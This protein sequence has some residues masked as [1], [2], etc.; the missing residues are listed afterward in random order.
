MVLKFILIIMLFLILII[1]VVVM[2]SENNDRKIF[3]EYLENRKKFNYRDRSRPIG[4]PK[5]GGG[6]FQLRSNNN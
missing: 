6:R 2:A 1:V 4:Q 5:K 3:D